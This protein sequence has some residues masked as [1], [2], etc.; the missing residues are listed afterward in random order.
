M[1]ESRGRPRQL[2]LH[3]RLRGFANDAWA[4]YAARWTVLGWTP[5]APV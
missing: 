3:E 2:E 1:A 5:C 4:L